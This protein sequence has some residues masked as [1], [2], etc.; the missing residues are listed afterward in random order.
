M[1]RS[2]EEF[3]E[4]LRPAGLAIIVV[5]NSLHNGTSSPYVIPTDLA[6][7]T[8]GKLVGFQ[9]E[10]VAVVRSLKRRLSGNHYLRESIIVLRKGNGRRH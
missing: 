2:L 6:V 7:A 9:V 3:Y 8:I 10:T 5:G 1:W 4:C